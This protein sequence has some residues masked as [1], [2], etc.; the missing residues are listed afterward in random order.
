MRE[1]QPVRVTV[2]GKGRVTSSPAGISCPGSCSHAF[3]AGTSV[4]LAARPARGRRFAGWSGACSG[5]GACTMRADRVR[6]VRA[7]FR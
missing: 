3:A 4:R 1:P 5:R 7:T 2:A 6:A